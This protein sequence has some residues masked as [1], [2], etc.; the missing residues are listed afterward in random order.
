MVMGHAVHASSSSET[1]SNTTLII[2]F[3]AILGPSDPP[4]VSADTARKRFAFSGTGD[5]LLPQVTLTIVVVVSQC[6]VGLTCGID[7]DCLS[8]F[9]PNIRPSAS[10]DNTFSG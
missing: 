4:I 6:D 10:V 3:I 8:R 2:T 7:R 5:E 1:W 9:E